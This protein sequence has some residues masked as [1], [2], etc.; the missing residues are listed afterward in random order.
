MLE[1]LE[2]I[3]AIM[4]EYEEANERVLRMEAKLG[5]QS[6]QFNVVK[7]HGQPREDQINELERLYQERLECHERSIEARREG[8][9][10]LEYINID[11]VKRCLEGFYLN[12]ESWKSLAIKEGVSY[13]YMMKLRKKGLDILREMKK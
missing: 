5:Y 9:I 12:L 1:K 4:K 7:G 6:P 8:K 2:E 10:L 13:V 3:R 11:R